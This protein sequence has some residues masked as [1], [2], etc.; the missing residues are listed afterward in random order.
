MILKSPVEKKVPKIYK[1]PRKRTASRRWPQF[2][3]TNFWK[4]AVPFDLI[5]DK[6]DWEIFFAGW[7][8]FVSVKKYIYCMKNHFRHSRN[9]FVG[10]YFLLDLMP[11]LTFT[12]KL[13][14]LHVQVL[15][16][17]ILTLHLYMLKG[18]SALLTGNFSFV[19]SFEIFEKKGTK[20]SQNLDSSC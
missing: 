2:F 17:K 4:T 10:Q 16:S 7:E 3:E 18:N 11:A 20:S 19:R 13:L 9:I 1:L 8:V 15:M 14:V 5:L 6:S 12:L